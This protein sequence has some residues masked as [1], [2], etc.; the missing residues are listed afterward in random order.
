MAYLLT[1]N[2]R[3]SALALPTERAVRGVLHGWFMGLAEGDPDYRGIANRMIEPGFMELG[4]A[5][6]MFNEYWGDR[7]TVALET[8]NPVKRKE[9]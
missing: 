6:D 4:E 9:D 8:F 3:K 2:G 7:I 1:V 5:V